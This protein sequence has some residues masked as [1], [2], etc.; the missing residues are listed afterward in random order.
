MKPEEYL[1]GAD[2][3]W[4]SL[5]KYSNK[6]NII[7]IGSNQPWKQGLSKYTNLW[8]QELKSA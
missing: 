3:N 1:V 4:N 8:M 7:R 5:D 2:A 6:I